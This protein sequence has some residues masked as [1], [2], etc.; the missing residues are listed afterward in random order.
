MFDFLFLTL[1]RVCRRQWWRE[2]V[3]PFVERQFGMNKYNNPTPQIWFI[4]V[5]S[6]SSQV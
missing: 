4:V 3:R 6:S 1:L 2:V 5:K